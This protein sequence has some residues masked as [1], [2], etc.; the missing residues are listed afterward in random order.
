VLFRSNLSITTDEFQ[1]MAIAAKQFGLEGDD[2]AA[3]LG[4]MAIAQADFVSGSPSAELIER[5]EALG[6]SLDE[7]DA[8]NAAQFFEAVAKGSQESA[9]GLDAS[10][11]MMGKTGPRFQAFMKLMAGA[12]LGGMIAG[13]KD[14]GEMISEEDIKATDAVVDGLVERWKNKAIKAAATVVGT[15]AGSVA[16]GA[17]VAQDAGADR[18]KRNKEARNRAD[19]KEAEEI[20]KDA[21]EIRK[22]TAFDLLDTEAKIVALKE[23]Q[24]AIDRKIAAA[25]KLKTRAELDKQRAEVEGKIAGL[26]AGKQGPGM[27]YD[28]L[29]RIGAGVFRGTA[30]D[31]IPKKQL[32][33]QQKMLGHLET[34]AKGEKRQIGVF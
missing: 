11:K 20:A 3:V 8:M 10:L 6:I 28:Q 15:V 18:A 22:K 25:T 31:V 26:E 7:A 13:A 19:Q 17:G 14:S 32:T 29:R 24:A 21:A 27:A 12:G 33:V 34:L 16:G 1:A 23:E 4:K 5:M 9:E 2:I 30:E